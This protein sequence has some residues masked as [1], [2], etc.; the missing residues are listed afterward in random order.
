MPKRTDI[1]KVMVIGSGPIVIVQRHLF[2]DLVHC[3]CSLF[4]YSPLHENTPVPRC[5]SPKRQAR[6]FSNDLTILIITIL[7]K[8]SN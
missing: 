2:R 4:L 5:S 6:K 3:V 7:K 1:K 8:E